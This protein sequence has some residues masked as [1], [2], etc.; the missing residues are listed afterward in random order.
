MERAALQTPVLTSDS[1]R[2]RSSAR[3][4]EFSA[5][6]CPTVVRKNLT[7]PRIRVNSHRLAAAVALA[8]PHELGLRTAV[9]AVKCSSY[10]FQSL[11][12]YPAAVLS[13]LRIS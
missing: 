8:F 5:A 13:R 12:V 9:L 11:A 10:G 6:T 3:V 4:Q 1:R 7:G 2:S